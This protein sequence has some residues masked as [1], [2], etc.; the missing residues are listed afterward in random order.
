MLARLAL[1]LALG[2]A[3]ACGRAAL[4]DPAGPAA[5]TTG[6]AA[7]TDGGAAG[8]AGAGGADEEPASQ[9]PCTPGADQTCND[10]PVM[11]ALAGM[12]VAREMPAGTSYC[13]CADGFSINPRTWR[14]RAGTECAASATD[15]WGFSASFDTQDCARRA[16]TSCSSLVD[17][18][19]EQAFF[20]LTA[21]RACLLPA[22]TTL[23]LELR[24]GCP[25][26]FEAHTDLPEGTPLDPS[27]LGCMAALLAGV[28]FECST[29]TDC[30]LIHFDPVGPIP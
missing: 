13:T 6:S 1:A 10:N 27:S 26:L 28:R 7:G 19:V 8:A 24:D 29:G 9:R 22:Y 15:A 23:R 30:A 4:L 14:C 16:V 20:A 3:T 21:D 5:G 18:P 25:T 17:R 11:S 12:C 2:A